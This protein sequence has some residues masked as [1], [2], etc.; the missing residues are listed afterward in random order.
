MITNLCRFIVLNTIGLLFGSPIV[1]GQVNLVLNP[2]FEDTAVHLVHGGNNIKDARYWNS[3]DTLSSYSICRS[4]FVSVYNSD[5]SFHIP[6]NNTFFYQWPRTGNSCAF[7]EIYG[8]DPWLGEYRNY[9]QGRFKQKLLANHQYCVSFYVNLSNKATRA[10]DRIGAYIDDGTIDSISACSHPIP[11]IIPQIENPAFNYISDT[12][13]W[14]KVEGVYTA[15]GHERFITIG[16]FYSN[17]NTHTLTVPGWVSGPL[18]AYLLDDVSLIDISEPN[19]AGNDTLLAPGCPVF[20]GHADDI[21]FTSEWTYKDS[22]S[23]ISTHAGIMVSDSSSKTYVVKMITGCAVLFDTITVSRDSSLKCIGV[24]IPQ[25]PSKQEA[26]VVYPNPN[27]GN[28]TIN[29]NRTE[30]VSFKLLNALGQTLQQQ[31]SIPLQTNYTI[32][33]NYNGVLFLQLL[34]ENGVI[35]ATKKVLCTD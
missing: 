10:I 7:I 16:N 17:A 22:S 28:F 32:H 18:S 26:F 29:Y 4:T 21:G 31:T 13:N 14:V 33:T 1:F 5:P 9:T 23:I 15:S 19:F 20:I 2:S 24:G 34:N 3:L 27:N 11:Y 30:K 25:T 6:S 8:W 12:L 35:V